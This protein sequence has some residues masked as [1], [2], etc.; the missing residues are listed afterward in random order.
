MATIQQPKAPTQPHFHRRLKQFMSQVESINEDLNELIQVSPLRPE[1]VKKTH[2]IITSSS[3]LDLFTSNSIADFDA[4]TAS[5]F[6]KPFSSSSAKLRVKPKSSFGEEFDAVSLKSEMSLLNLDS[7]SCFLSL[8]R[9]SEVNPLGEPLE[10][11][12]DGQAEAAETLQR[13]WRML[14]VRRSYQKFLRK[15]KMAEVLAEGLEET[16]RVGG[17]EEKK[18]EKLRTALEKTKKFQKKMVEKIRSSDGSRGK[19]EKKVRVV[20]CM[21]L[22]PVKN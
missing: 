3:N 1:P 20:S 6:R 22:E 17:L 13:Y 8:E 21:E 16:I 2:K 14:R 18:R 9:V 15:I 4:P 11:K 12:G 5:T 10:I 19:K 7:E